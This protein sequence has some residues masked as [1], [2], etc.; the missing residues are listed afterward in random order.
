MVLNADIAVYTHR[1]QLS[2]LQKAAC[3]II[4]QGINLA[5]TI[6]ELIRQSY[7]FGVLVLIRPLIE[8]TTTISYFQAKPNEVEVWKAG[9]QY[10]NRLTLSIMLESKSDKHNRLESRLILMKLRL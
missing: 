5:L 10:R 1:T 8:R 2:D 3:Q 9:W 7:L 4:P 6:R